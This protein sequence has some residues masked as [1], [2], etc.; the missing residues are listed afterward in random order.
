M[1]NLIRIVIG[2]FLDVNENTGEIQESY[3]SKPLLESSEL[4]QS[5]Y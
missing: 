4:T 2:T 1:L 3:L 5:I